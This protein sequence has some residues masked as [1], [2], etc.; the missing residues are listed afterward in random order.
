MGRTG[1]LIISF[2]FILLQGFTQETINFRQADS[3]TFA[4]YMNGDW[5]AVISTGKLALD[6]EIDYF[7]QRLRMGVA[8]YNKQNYRAASRH[9]Y[10]ADK[11]NPANGITKEYRYYSYL[12]SGRYDE[13][14]YVS[15]SM[16]NRMLE[17]TGIPKPPFF[18]LL[19][20]EAGPESGN[21]FEQNSLGQMPRRQSQRWQDLYGNSIYGHLGVKMNLHP[22]IGVYLGYSYLSINKKAELQY[23]WNEPDSIVERAWGFAKF[24]PSE[25]KLG[26]QQY[27]YTLLQNG[28]YFKADL[29]L[30]RGW[31][32]NPAFHYVNV[33]TKSINIRNNT[34][35]VQDTAFYIAAIDSVNYFFY[36][37]R[38]FSIDAQDLVLNNV[39]LSLGINKQVSIFDLGLFGSWSNLNNANQVQFGFTA[40]YYPLGNLN[41]YGISTL[42]GISTDDEYWPVFGQ[43]I[44]FR[45]FTFLWAEAFGVFGNLSGTNE[46]D[47][48]VVYNISDDINLKTGLKLTFVLSPS[49]Q[50]TARYQYLQK[51]G[52]R[53]I[54]GPEV[55]PGQNIQELDYSNHSIIGGLQWIF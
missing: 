6:N 51:T 24:F 54:S 47:A 1:I 25:S 4:A 53:Y 22:R 29:Y 7:Y 13:A 40:A 55:M 15:G 11:F 41:L 14:A 38:S 9:L 16:D 18:S 17:I 5:D 34:R 10:T 36:D 44:G 28:I 3:V 49:V 23:W 20:A 37:R 35:T 43:V 45:T 50:I 32:L 46:S 30:G 19:N 8:Y 39:V 48:F 52:F 31:S 42:K 33:N 21:N 27:E 26:Y 12:F 2:S